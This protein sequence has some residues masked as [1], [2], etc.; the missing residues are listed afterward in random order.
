LNIR[1]NSTG[2][3]KNLTR[4]RIEE[5]LSLVGASENNWHEEILEA[6]SRFWKN[7]LA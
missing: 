3:E 5:G 6:Y 7:N 2:P 1:F 4:L